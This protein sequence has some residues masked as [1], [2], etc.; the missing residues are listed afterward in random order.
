ME[1]LIRPD[2]QFGLRG[3]AEKFGGSG[4]VREYAA[5]VLAAWREEHEGYYG[6]PHGALAAEKAA[7]EIRG[8]SIHAGYVDADAARWIL[9]HVLE[10]LGE[11]QEALGCLQRDGGDVFGGW[12]TSGGNLTLVGVGVRGR[13]MVEYRLGRRHGLRRVFERRARGTSPSAVSYISTQSPGA[14]PDDYGIEPDAAT[15]A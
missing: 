10:G 12:L 15:K 4:G 9:L 2:S 11:T 13:V 6:A 3:E 5:E 8:I 14:D 1:V 7:M